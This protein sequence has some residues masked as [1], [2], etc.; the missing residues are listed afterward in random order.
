M[1][2]LFIVVIVLLS[3]VL[4]IVIYGSIHGGVG[5]MLEKERQY[6]TIEA[7]DSVEVTVFIDFFDQV[8]RVDSLYLNA[9]KNLLQ[10]K[11]NKR[12]SEPFKMAEIKKVVFQIN[13]DEVFTSSALEKFEELS[14][15]LMAQE[16][17]DVELILKLKLS[18]HEHL[19]AFESPVRCL[20]VIDTL[21]RWEA[22]KK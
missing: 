1:L 12:L 9:S 13:D 19:I 2:E 3:L 18:S 15:F 6:N 7:D 5:K 22:Q 20:L 16:L 17:E 14:D 4:A 21:K 8:K 11:K 10:L